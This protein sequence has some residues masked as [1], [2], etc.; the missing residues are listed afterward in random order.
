MP[1]RDVLSI[2]DARRQ[3]AFLDPLPPV[4]EKPLK[5]E[6]TNG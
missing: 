1:A 6:R 3:D 4:V 2:G 5:R